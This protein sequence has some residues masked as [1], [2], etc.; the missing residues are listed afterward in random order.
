MCFLPGSARA[1]EAAAPPRRDALVRFH[2]VPGLPHTR[3][4]GG[5]WAPGPRAAASEAGSVWGAPPRRLGRRPEVTVFLDVVPGG[6]P[7]CLS[8]APGRSTCRPRASCGLVCVPS[9]HAHSPALASTARFWSPR[10]GALVRSTPQDG[11][12]R[13]PLSGLSPALER[14]DEFQPLFETRVPPGRRFLLCRA[15]PARLRRGRPARSL[16]RRGRVLWGRG[17]PSLPLT[18]LVGVP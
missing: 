12:V 2:G 7:D 18:R 6:L 8:P 4:R 9:E 16:W 1:C 11:P 3:E 15:H 14:A 17:G 5:A 10:I 13:G